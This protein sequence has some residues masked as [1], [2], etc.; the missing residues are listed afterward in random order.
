MVELWELP[1]S[2]SGMARAAEQARA[3]TALEEGPIRS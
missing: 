1:M 2:G 3:E